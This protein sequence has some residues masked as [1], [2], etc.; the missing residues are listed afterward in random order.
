MNK[1][2]KLECTIC[3]ETVKR[4]SRCG[5]RDK[6]GRELPP[7][8]TVQC[9][10]LYLGDPPARSLGQEVRVWCTSNRAV[11]VMNVNTTEDPAS[12]AQRVAADRGFL[13]AVVD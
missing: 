10:S 9:L 5:C 6:K 3:C 8:V 7:V 12:R 2:P 4:G 1:R 13:I 11:W